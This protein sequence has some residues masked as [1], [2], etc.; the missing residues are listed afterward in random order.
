VSVYEI[1]WRRTPADAFVHVGSIRAKSRELALPLAKE[2]YLRRDAPD[3]IWVVDREDIISSLPEDRDLL[4]LTLDKEYRLPTH[5]TRHG[6]EKRAQIAAREHQ[7]QVP[8]AAEQMM[9]QEP[10]TPARGL[11]DDA[12]AAD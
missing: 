10:Q 2:N 12:G 6:A 5:F 3:A 7:T 1:F 9:A 8:G 4:A 11:M